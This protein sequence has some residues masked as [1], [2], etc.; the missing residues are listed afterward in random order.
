[1]RRSEIDRAIED[2]LEFVDRMGFALPPFARWTVGEW[3]AAGPE[4]D[5]VRDTMLGW[6]VSDF[7]SG[8]FA[9]VGILIFVLR[10]GIRADP[11]YPKPYAEKI[12][13][14]AENQVVPFH[15]HFLKMED[16]INR[17][18]GNLIVELASSGPDLEL[19]D[20]PTTATV[21]GRRSDVRRGSTLALRP[22]Q[23]ISIPP[24]QYHR[25]WAEPGSGRVL[26]GEVSSVND[27]RVDNYFPEHGIR[28]P[29]IV[30]DRPARYVLFSDHSR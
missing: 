5:E 2:G 8:D 21:D 26:A 4:M 19:L 18:G 24:R 9:R 15:L 12:L 1:M 30:E 28:L 13:I 7:G 25:F 17:G 20:T 3:R 23:S 10:N 27:D 16:I 22:G 11:R 29:E 6:D 14:Q